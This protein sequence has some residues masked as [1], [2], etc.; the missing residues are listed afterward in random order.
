LYVRVG[1]RIV[2][3]PPEDQAVLERYAEFPDKG[4]VAH[5]YRLTILTG[6]T[7]YRA[8]EEVRV[9]HVCEAVEPGTELFVMGPKQVYGEEVDGVPVTP[10]PL[11]ID[12][13]RPAEYDGRVLPGPAADANY[14]IT[15]YR[16]DAPGTHTI[17]W[18]PRSPAS[19]ELRLE[20]V[21]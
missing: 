10:P 18:C 5:G 3:A 2:P 7:S 21:A 19:N 14:E 1:D 8:G 12:P 17:R 20:I 15:S 9:V 4:P 13:L 11:G 6:R 16:F